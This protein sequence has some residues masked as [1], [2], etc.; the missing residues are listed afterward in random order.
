VRERP[1]LSIGMA[2]VAGYII[3]RLTGTTTIY[4]DRR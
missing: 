3:G 4:R 1:L 2:A